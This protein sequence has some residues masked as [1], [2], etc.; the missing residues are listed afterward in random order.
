MYPYYS[1][2]VVS[3]IS[4]YNTLFI[5]SECLPKYYY[6]CSIQDTYIRSRWFVSMYDSGTVYI[7]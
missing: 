1:E 3:S 2:G 4:N 5:T 7:V 6:M